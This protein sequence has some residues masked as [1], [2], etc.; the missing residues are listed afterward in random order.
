[1]VHWKS[2][3]F[4]TKHSQSLFPTNTASDGK[5][6]VIPFKIPWFISAMNKIFKFISFPT[7][8]KK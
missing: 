2:R 5:N 7:K 8:K 1:M 6:S 3:M 4:S